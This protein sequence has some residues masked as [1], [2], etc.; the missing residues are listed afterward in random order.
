MES[1]IAPAIHYAYHLR[2]VLLASCLT[3]QFL[4]LTKKEDWLAGEKRNWRPNWLEILHTTFL[5][6]WTQLG[7]TNQTFMSR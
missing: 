1:D 2:L 4:E 7:S 5:G 6:E 3:I